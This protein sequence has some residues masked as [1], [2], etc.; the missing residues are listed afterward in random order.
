[1]A[2]ALVNS[3]VQNGTQPLEDALRQIETTSELK[4]HMQDFHLS[5]TR[6]P[7]SKQIPRTYYL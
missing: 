3:W 4:E 5:K 6:H 2:D 7:I 1:M